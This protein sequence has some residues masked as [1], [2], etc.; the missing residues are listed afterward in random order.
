MAT[1]IAP[2]PKLDRKSSIKFLAQVERNL[3]KTTKAV[4]TPEIDNTINFI[5]ND[6]LRKT[7]RNP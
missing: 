3:K 7:Q 6:A 5:M 1:P 2:T 4:P